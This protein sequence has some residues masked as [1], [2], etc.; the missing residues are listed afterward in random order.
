M[1]LRSISDLLFII[2]I[3]FYIDTGDPASHYRSTGH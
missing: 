2:M 3:A 1:G